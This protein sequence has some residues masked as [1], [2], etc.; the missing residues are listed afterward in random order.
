MNVLLGGNILH[1]GNTVQS[2]VD[3]S[4]RACKIRMP[5]KEWASYF[6]AICWFLWR[7]RNRK[8]FE[9]C[10][11]DPVWIAFHANREAKLWLKFC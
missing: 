6:F 11:T 9:D 8:I 4:W 1:L 10:E 7:A 2:T 5:R 3:K